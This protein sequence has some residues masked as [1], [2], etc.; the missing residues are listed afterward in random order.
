MII[1]HAA[2]TGLGSIGHG[3]LR[4]V[5]PYG[6]HPRDVTIRGG[7][8]AAIAPA[9][10]PAG[11]APE[12]DAVDI[13]AVGLVMLPGFV[14]LHTHL[15]DPGDGRSET[16][17]SGTR[18]AAAGGFTDVFAMANTDPVTDTAERVEA[19]A[20]TA[21]RGASARV[22]PVGAITYGLEGTSLTDLPA[23][24]AA[25]AQLFSDDGKCVDDA[26]IMFAALEQ[27]ALHD[28]VLAQHAQH[29]QLAGRGQINAGAAAVRTGLPPWHAA[30][31][32]T[33]IARDVI[34]A[35]HARA[36]LH[37]CHISTRGSVE[38]IR[39]A[40]SQGWNIT[41]EVTPHHLLLTDE[42]T[43]LS[44]PRYKVN[45]PLRTD[46]DVRAL[47]E[48]LRDGTVDAIA[49]DHAPHTADSKK[50]TWCDAPFGMTALETALPVAARVLSETGGQQWP[51]LAKLMSTNPAR[52]GSISDRA[53]RPIAVGEPAT[54]ALIDPTTRFTVRDN[55]FHSLST[56]SP[57]TGE[58]FT[59]RVVATAIDGQLTHIIPSIASALNRTRP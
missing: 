8:I 41:C 43:A 24:A 55:E 46:D 40:K 21:R 22:H 11:T 1:D 20:E 10:G 18:A 17:A 25:G 57:F 23:L 31:E 52:I 16:V 30:A 3:T 45:P 4:S 33:V 15:R 34:L 35:G 13:D 50:R 36:R 2:I 56:N 26:E 19:V 54:F 48:A 27:A 51:L 37:I 49:T 5:R 29:G 42:L 14:D 59:S 6:G 9:L 58:S 53:G 7:R 28:L 39:W 38:V 12:T 32:E 44:D 47:R